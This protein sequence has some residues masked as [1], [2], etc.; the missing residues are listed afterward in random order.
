MTPMN[1]ITSG[2][3]LVDVG[4]TVSSWVANGPSVATGWGRRDILLAETSD[5]G[6][7]NS[8]GIWWRQL[9]PFNND[10]PG[11]FSYLPARGQYEPCLAN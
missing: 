5:D 1:G 10:C 11:P 7:V 2:L 3:P 8:W 6:A 9:P 4:I